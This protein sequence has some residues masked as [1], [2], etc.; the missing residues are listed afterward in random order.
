MNS[1]AY[2]ARMPRE[3]SVDELHEDTFDVVA[4]VGAGERVVVTVDGASVAEIVPL[5]GFRSP[6]VSSD[7][8]RRICAD[9][10]LTVVSSRC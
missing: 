2:D 6:R 4:A 8:I 10:L 1:S 5:G 3:I 9:S 7:E